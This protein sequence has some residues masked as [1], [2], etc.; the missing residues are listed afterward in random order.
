MQASRSWVH[1]LALLAGALLVGAGG[2]R[3]PILAGDGAAQLAAIAAMPGWRA[4]HWAIALGYVLVVAG[5]SGALSR[6]AET[7]GA[8]AA[9]T[10]MFLSAFGYLADLIGVAFMLGAASALAAAYQAGE[11]GLAAT[12]A[13][14]VFDMLHPAAH[15]AL[16]VGAFAVSLGLA[17]FGWSVLASAAWPRWLG[18]I[19]VWGGAGGVA[20]ALAVPGGSPY[21]IAGV[22]LATVWQLGAALM[23]LRGPTPAAAR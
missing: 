1:G 20:A 14:F 3:H 19:G 6:L 9:R 22:G 7:A 16:R 2:L 4:L 15:A 12:N 23:L 8:P 21:A 5:L 18:W 17:A 10:G 11:P 13:V